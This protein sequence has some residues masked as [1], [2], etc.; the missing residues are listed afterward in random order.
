M[1]RFAPSFPL[2]ACVACSTAPV[3]VPDASTVPRTATGSFAVTIEL[4]LAAPIPG[5]RGIGPRRALAGDV[6]TQTIRRDYLV[7]WP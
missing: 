1:L 6:T 3:A 4:E 2:V 5:C 7:H